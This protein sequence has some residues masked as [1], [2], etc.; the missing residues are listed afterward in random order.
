MI[1]A[2]ALTCR[3]EETKNVSFHVNVACL[4]LFAKRHASHIGII[5]LY[6]C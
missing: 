2:S 5:T 4:G 1:N 6:H 3:T